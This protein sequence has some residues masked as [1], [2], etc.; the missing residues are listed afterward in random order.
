MRHDCDL[1]H[2]DFFRARDVGHQFFFNLK[3]VFLET[4]CFGGFFFQFGRCFVLGFGGSSL[5]FFELVHGGQFGFFLVVTGKIQ[6][7]KRDAHHQNDGQHNDT[8]NQQN[9]FFL[10]RLVRTGFG[11]G[12]RCSGCHGNLLFN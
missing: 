4:C 11:F 5:E 6:G 12:L 1:H 9:R 10:F 8:D 2:H 7:T 3:I